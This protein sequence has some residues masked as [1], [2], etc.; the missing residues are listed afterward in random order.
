MRQVQII[1]W[2][3]VCLSVVLQSCLDDEV[4]DFPPDDPVDTL[5]TTSSVA[6]IS[7][8]RAIDNGYLNENEPCVEFFYPIELSFNNGLS[9]E[10][11]NYEGLREIASSSTKDLHIDGIEF[12]FLAS[13]LGTLRNIEDETGFIQ[14]LEDC[15]LLTLRDEFDKYYT[16][17]IDFDY[18]IQMIDLSGNEV[19]I[20]S[21]ADYFEFE[22]IQGFEAQ[23][24]FV[25]PL[26]V[27][28]FQEDILTPVENYFEL[29]QTFN[30]CEKCPQPFFFTDWVADST[31]SFFAEFEGIQNLF[32]YEWIINDEVVEIDGFGVQ[33][34]NKLTETF[35]Q[36]N[37][38]ICIRT[39]TDDCVAGTY[40]CE[41]LELFCPELSFEYEQVNDVTYEFFTNFELKDEIDYV[42]KIYQGDDLI[43]TEE[44]GPNGDDILFFQFE[45]GLTYEVCVF[46]VTDG[47][48]QGS[49]FCEFIEL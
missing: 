10:V 28:I 14:L 3:F 18:P 31:Y 24:V 25:F 29:F 21:Q 48:P 2:L 8:L 45:L 7:L 20:G 13:K 36:G 16:Q 47:C 22:F 5:T 38:E 44:E 19:S 37:Y 46:A 30:D 27:N 33:G 32:S 43:H 4:L 42:W 49:E 23:P 34:D 6:I 9:I 41:N 1:I 15:D 39:T 11:S 26:T 17:C 40:Y 35:S 12:P